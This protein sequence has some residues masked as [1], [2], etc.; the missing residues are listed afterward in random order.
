MNRFFSTAALSLVLL[1]GCG[2]RDV[3]LPGERL[4]L[5][6]GM[7][8][9]SEA[10]ANETRPLRLPAATTNADW[11][12][13]NGGPTHVAGHPALGSALQ[14]AF[15][16]NVGEGN[17]RRA[18]MTADP[19]VAGGVIYTLDARATVSATGTNGAPLWTRDV[20]PG[21]DSTSSASGGGIAFANGMLF[22]A[23][24]FGELTALNAQTGA[25][26]WTQNLDAPGG[27]AP[28]VRDG[29]VYVVSRDSRAWAIEADT[30]RIRWTIDGAPSASGFG[31]GAGVAVTGE[32]AF[33]PFPSGE[34]LA[35]FPRGGLRR[36]SSVVTGQRLGSAA[37]TVSD[38]AADPVV[39]GNRLYV[40]NSSG[41]VVAM[42][43]ATGD[44][45]WTATEGAV[46]PVWPAGDSLFFINDRNEL[47]RMDSGDGGVVWRIQL[48]TFEEGRERRQKTLY[49]HFGPIIAGG[50]VIVAS[51]DGAL[52]QFD[53]ASGALIGQVEIPGGAASNPV[54]AGQVLYLLNTR[55]QLLAFR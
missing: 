3:T 34:V 45:L 52:R 31:G 53:P 11:T 22:V 23:T 41:R 50:R 37:A 14:L 1:A 8:G 10:T 38:I 36:W 43:A 26:V 17:S 2:E 9:T 39:V 24:G 49:A 12:H 13:R 4:D 46:G 21:Y 33:F 25:E 51:S 5:R 44:R 18:R 16:V 48:P 30:G 40:G 28:T 32:L 35:A 55:G 42:E 7:V 47:V 27:S 15:Q 6:D 19:V 29:L 54:V 20:T